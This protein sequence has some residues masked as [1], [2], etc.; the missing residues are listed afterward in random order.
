M[1][2]CLKGVKYNNYSFICKSQQIHF[3]SCSKDADI[4]FVYIIDIYRLSKG[5]FN[6]PVERFGIFTLYLKFYQGLTTYDF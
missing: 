3:L 6:T 2:F 5:L 1:D 4:V